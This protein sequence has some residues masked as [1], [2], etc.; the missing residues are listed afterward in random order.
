MNIKSLK[1]NLAAIVK[2]PNSVD[3]WLTSLHQLVR[4]GSPIDASQEV[5]A[6]NGIKI[7]SDYK[8]LLV[9]IKSSTGSPIIVT[10]NPRVT[11]GGID[12]QRVTLEGASNTATVELQ[13]GNGIK[14]DAG[15]SFIFTLNDMLTLRYNK[16]Q[17]LWLEVSRSKN[18]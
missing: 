5:V 18:T 3:T 10:A 1:P 4:N 14:L 17:N 2:D 13:T 11:A 9:R 12:G 8:E 15:A 6:A 16:S 7:N